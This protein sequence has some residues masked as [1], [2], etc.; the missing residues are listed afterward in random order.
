LDTSKTYATNRIIYHRGDVYLTHV[1][2]QRENDWYPEYEFT[3]V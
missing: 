1:C 2:K 3:K